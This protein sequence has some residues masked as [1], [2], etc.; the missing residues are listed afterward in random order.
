MYLKQS[1]QV[2]SFI[3]IK[4]L[5]EIINFLFDFIFF[6]FGNFTLGRSVDKING[7]Y[8]FYY[9][10]DFESF[11]AYNKDLLFYES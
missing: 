6:K 5:Q 1:Y 3:Y 7:F 2:F 4:F 10:M 11:M 8:T 9:Y